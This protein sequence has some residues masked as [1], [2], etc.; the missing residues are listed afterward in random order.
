MG[1]TTTKA[2][3]TAQPTA[4]RKEPQMTQMV[5]FEQ[6]DLEEQ[7]SS[8]EIWKWKSTHPGPPCR[9]MHDTH[10]NKLEDFMER[11][12]TSPSALKAVVQKRRGRSFCDE[13]GMEK[14]HI[15]EL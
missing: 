6:R 13:L 14:L 4:A 12:E 8:F 15:L 9:K 1:C 10:I 3:A 11:V 7:D 5:D 2:V